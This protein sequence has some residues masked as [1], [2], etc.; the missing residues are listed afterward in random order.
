MLS[1]EFYHTNTRR[2]T[3]SPHMSGTL[4]GS[5]G[6]GMGKNDIIVRGLS[7]ADTT[8]EIAFTPFWFVSIL[9]QVGWLVM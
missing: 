5:N 8:K 1:D 6:A 4:R 2:H 3:D 7:L 9:R